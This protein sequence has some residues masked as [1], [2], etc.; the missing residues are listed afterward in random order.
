MDFEGDP[1][2]TIYVQAGRGKRR[3]A[4]LN[5]GAANSIL[6][7]PFEKY[8]F[9]SGYEAICCYENK[10]IEAGLRTTRLP[11]RNLL[12][13]LVR[14]LS[15]GEA[16]EQTAIELRPP[17]SL[18]ARPT[19]E[20]G[21]CSPE[22]GALTGTHSSLPKITLKLKGARATQH[23]QALAELRSYGDSLFFQLDM[24]YGSTF[25][26]ERERRFRPS[27][28]RQFT[29]EL[30]Y[31]VAHYNEEAMSLYW[32]AKSASDMPLLTYLAFYQS[33]EFYLPKILS[34]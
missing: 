13:R 27:S 9:L 24:M 8:R 21:P 12:D 1:Y 19:I 31:P 22:F 7:V 11:S 23:D 17:K 34:D 2:A 4:V 26:L 18:Q 10:V 33:I 32:Y 14:H 20:I 29:V 25:I 30:A 5:T 28:R 3:L 15:G 16:A 6:S